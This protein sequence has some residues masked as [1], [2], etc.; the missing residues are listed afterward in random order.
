MLKFWAVFLI[1]IELKQREVSLVCFGCYHTW[2]I[3]RKGWHTGPAWFKYYEKRLAYL[4]LK[5]Y[6]V[7]V[8]KEGRIKKKTE[9][10]D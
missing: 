1:K 10:K 4:I 9:A 2:E 8:S 6:V 5:V 3:S 7:F